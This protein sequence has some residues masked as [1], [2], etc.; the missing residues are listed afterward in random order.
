MTIPEWDGC[1]CRNCPATRH[2]MLT[3]IEHCPAC[4]EV[5]TG[6]VGG[7]RVATSARVREACVCRG[8]REQTV[9]VCSICGERQE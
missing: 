1:C 9:A 3:T 4:L 2:Y 8:T 6:D 7:V 5:E